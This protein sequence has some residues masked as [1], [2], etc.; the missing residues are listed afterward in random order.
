MLLFM[1][2]FI[3]LDGNCNYR[4]EIVGGRRRPAMPSLFTRL[5]LALTQLARLDHSLRVFVYSKVPHNMI[6]L[7]TV[8]NA[9]LSATNEAFSPIF[10]WRDH[11]D[12]KKGSPNHMY[13][14]FTFWSKFCKKIKFLRFW[15]FQ[16]NSACTRNLEM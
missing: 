2:V 8:G 10:F 7:Y 3:I 13:H 5:L 6:L 16:A 9:E 14:I 15:I 4:F 12:L 1:V 11:K